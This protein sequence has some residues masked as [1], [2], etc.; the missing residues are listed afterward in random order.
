[1]GKQHLA[2][3]CAVFVGAA[4]MVAALVPGTAS[5][6][7]G[8]STPALKIALVYQTDVPADA[9]FGQGAQAAANQLGFHL[10]IVGPSTYNVATQQQLSNSEA[11][12]GANGIMEILV[13]ATPW[14]RNITALEG[15]HIAVTDI[16]VYTG[17]FLGKNT[18]VYVGPSDKAYGRALGNLVAQ[19]IGPNAHGNVVVATCAPGLLEQV[20]RYQGVVQVMKQKEPGVKVLG[21]DF[22]TDSYTQ[23]LTDWQRIVLA[24][25]NALAFIGLCST[26]PAVLARVKASDHG[27]WLISGGELDPNTLIGIKDGLI[28]GVVDAEIW[29]Q[30]Y[31][32]ARLLYDELTNP[33]YW[34]RTGWINTGVETVT[35]ANIDAV[36]ARQSS[37][38]AQIAANEPSDD[39][40]FSNLNAHIQPLLASQS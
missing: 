20:Q 36:I 4:T 23:G 21:P 16:G 10:N 1:M 40:L 29:Q 15:R 35:K 34:G 13:G 9:P 14:T 12:A 31:I 8:S 28:Y 30:G 22:A 33:K 39:A 25:P 2:S 19:G 18:P 3:R 11:N 38:T 6:S 26:A 17:P 7:S 37:P 32:G 24:N 5:A 27:K